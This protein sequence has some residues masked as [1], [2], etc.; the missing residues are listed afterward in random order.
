MSDKRMG[1][2]MGILGVLFAGTG[3]YILR[4]QMPKDFYNWETASVDPA[5]HVA[6]WF[7]GFL[8]SPLAVV[9]SIAGVAFCSGGCAIMARAKG[10]SYAWAWFGLT[11]IVGVLVVL[12]LPS[13]RDS[14]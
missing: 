2:A 9:A 1:I 6:R 14:N 5:K 13:R 12:I 10:R 4:K 3:D 11:T 8:N 7:T